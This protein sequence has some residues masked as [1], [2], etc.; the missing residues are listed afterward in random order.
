MISASK[1]GQPET[2]ERLVALFRE[3]STV[4]VGPHGGTLTPLTGAGPGIILTFERSRLATVSDFRRQ[5]A[6][7]RY[8]IDKVVAR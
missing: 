8:K 3:P 4:P 1:D 5:V 7:L 6:M 2:R